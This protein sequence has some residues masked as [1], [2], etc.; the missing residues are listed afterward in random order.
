MIVPHHLTKRDGTTVA[1][2]D[3][4]FRVTPGVVTGFL[5][6]TV[7]EVHHDAHDHAARPDRLGEHNHQRRSRPP[8]ARPASDVMNA[9]S[10]ASVAPQPALLSATVG[11]LLMTAHTVAVIWLGAVLLQRR[12]A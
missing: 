5:A 1:V 9:N 11:F 12:D 4:T 2:D 10:V 3:L 8:H 7:R 6:P